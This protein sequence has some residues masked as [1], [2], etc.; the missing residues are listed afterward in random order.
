MQIYN[1][2][3]FLIQILFYGSKF[4]LNVVSCKDGV[5]FSYLSGLLLDK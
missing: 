3:D 5:R 1:E 4:H 2:I